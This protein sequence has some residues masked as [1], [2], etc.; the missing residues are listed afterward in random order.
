[1]QDGWDG[2]F[3]EV[4]RMERGIDKIIQGEES[5]DRRQERRGKSGDVF[6][7]VWAGMLGIVYCQ[8]YIA[9][10][11]GGEQLGIRGWGGFDSG[12]GGV[13]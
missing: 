12:V 13:N 7:G 9:Y 10:W 6:G 3:A 5:G 8:L 2:S 1:M 11:I 4:N